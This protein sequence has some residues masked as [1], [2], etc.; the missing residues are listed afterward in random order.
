MKTTTKTT[1][2]LQMFGGWDEVLKDPQMNTGKTEFTKLQ[3]GVT[4]LRF[5]DDEPFVRWAHWIAQAKR[6]VSCIGADCP[7]CEAIKASRQAGMKPNYTSSR[8][9]A[10]HVLNLNT[11]NVEMLEQGKTFFTQLHAL[12][13]EIGNVK[14]YNIKVKT[15]NAGSTDVTYT[16]LPCA[17]SELS[18]EQMELTK[19]LKPFDEVFKKPTREQVIQLMSGKSPEEVFANKSNDKDEEIG[20]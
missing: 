12:H 11:G 13:E 7:V 5:L 9:F 8:K 3:N 20:L 1:M 16:L 14:G 10:M 17:P 19:E 2:D 18:T 4:E 6:N 15:Q